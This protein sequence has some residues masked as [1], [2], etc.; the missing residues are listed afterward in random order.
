MFHVEQREF[1]ASPDSP[2]TCQTSSSTR[3][4]ATSRW[5]FNGVLAD[6]PAILV[7]KSPGGGWRKKR[8]GVQRWRR[9]IPA[10]LPLLSQTWSNL[11]SLPPVLSRFE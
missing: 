4:A 5:Q 10:S 8:A 2:S 1:A 7:P 3:N 9:P 6:F 11:I